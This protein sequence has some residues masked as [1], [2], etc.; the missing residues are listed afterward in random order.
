MVQTDSDWLRRL[1]FFSLLMSIIG[2]PVILVSF[3][4]LSWIVLV[5]DSAFPVVA[6][7]GS[8]LLLIFGISWDTKY[9]M[10]GIIF[11][12][13]F[14]NYLHNSETENDRGI[15]RFSFL[16]LFCIIFILFAL[17]YGIFRYGL[18]STIFPL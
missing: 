10:G 8:L 15:A 7:F 13:P 11:I 4:I 2:W 6:Q 14:K 3:A 16:S 17:I 9:N 12:R 18:L 1:E 5:P